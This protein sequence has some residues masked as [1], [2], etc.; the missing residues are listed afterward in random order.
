MKID[1][2]ASRLAWPLL[3]L[4]ALAAIYLPSLGNPQVFDDDA[5]TD[6]RIFGVYGSLADWRPRWLSYGSFVWL[7]TW[8]GESWPMQRAFNLLAHVGATL[9]LWGLYR[10][11]LKSIAAPD[12]APAGA[13][14]HRSPALG[15]A[16]GFFALN[17][18]A[19]YAVAYLVQRSILMATLFVLLGLWTFARGLRGNPLW[20]GAALVCYALAVL[21]KEHALMAPLAAVPVYVLVARPSGR[22]LAMLAGVGA[23]L[24]GAAGALLASRYGEILGKPFDEFSKIYL[25]QLAALG[26]EVE[27][28]AYALSLLNQ[29]WLFF[30]YGLHWLIPYAGWMAIDLRPPFPVS[31]TTFPHLFGAFG[32]LAVLVGGFFLVIRYRDWRALLG[33]SLLL[34]ALL[35]VTEFA[36]VWVQDP[37]VLY[38]SY[39]WAIGVPGLVFFLFHGLPGR[40]LLP[41][42]VVLA[43]LLVWQGLDRIYTLS[44]PERLWSDAIARLPDDPRSV[45][46]WFPYL[47]RGNL[48]LEQG[49]TREAF[50]DFQASSALGDKGMGQFNMAALLFKAGQHGQALD[51]V[52]RAERAGYD[53]PGLR[54]QRGV[55]L[56]A[57]GRLG[58]AGRELALALAETPDSPARE[59]VLAVKGRVALEM[60][61]LDAA[62]ADFANALALNPRHKKARA[63]LGMV[64]VAQRDFAGARALFTDLIEEAPVAAVHYGRALAHHGLGDRAAALADIERALVMDPGNPAMTE[65]RTRI[66]AMR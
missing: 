51:A 34:P 5:L 3:V 21:S 15:L 44:K 13:D 43:G 20:H 57:L 19:V 26:P 27:T 55:I 46:R 42:G 62:R 56:H 39:L 11:L 2:M 49:R 45:G 12:D 61:Q 41:L 24:V 35:F 60:G 16:V 33:V 28:N 63:D 53:F 64:L 66:R 18:V 48:L 4:L 22:R 50:E 58:E 32:Y 65:W 7:Q 38:R 37:F 54:Y 6:G 36:T 10:E 40:V 23:L 17:P 31:L 29:T 9:A 14:Y 8:F 30:Q 1:E 47:V 52:D 59:E 25:A